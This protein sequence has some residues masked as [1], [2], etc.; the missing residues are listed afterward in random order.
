MHR[1]GGRGSDGGDG[2]GDG[3]DG[4]DGG[5]GG[6]TTGELLAQSVQPVRVT[7]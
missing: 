2:G 7:L 4:S 3:G 5:G 1:P 6:S